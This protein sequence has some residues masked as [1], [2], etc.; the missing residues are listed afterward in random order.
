MPIAD[1]A[2][3][4]P[5]AKPKSWG[6]KYLHLRKDHDS[7]SKNIGD[8]DPASF[9]F[10]RNNITGQNTWAVEAALGLV[11]PIVDR[12]HPPELGNYY[13]VEFNTVTSAALN[14]ITGTGDGSLDIADS[15]A[16]RAGLSWQLQARHLESTWWNYQLFNLDYRATGTTSGGGF[17]SGGE[18]GWEPTRD[19]KDEWFAINGAVRPFGHTDIPFMYAVT[20]ASRLEFGEDQN[21]NSFL[22]LGPKVGCT[23]VP[24]FLPNLS[25]FG[26]YTY[27][28]EAAN[29]ERDFDYLETGFRWTL[30]QAEQIF[31]EGKYRFGQLPAKYTDIDLFQIALSLKF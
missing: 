20:I 24:T 1:A 12:N 2:A 23:L 25:L 26:N 14:R 15:L 8:A 13:M 31:L 22:K 18:F 16:L 27:M 21:N 5:L 29:G 30:D 28:W 7:L 6:P 19:R 3:T 17:K 9:G 4:I 10:Y 11:I